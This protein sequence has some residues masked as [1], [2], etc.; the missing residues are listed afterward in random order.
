MTM[1]PKPFSNI[2]LMFGKLLCTLLLVALLTPITYFTWRASQPMDFPEFHGLAYSQLLTERQAAYDQ[3]AYSYQASH[4]NV[5]VKAGICFDSELGIEIV[6]A[7]PY[8]GL[9]T[10]A[11]VFP[12]LKQH[13]NPLD[14]QRGYIPENITPMKFLPAWW[15]TFEKLVWGLVEYIPEGPVVY[16]RIASLETKR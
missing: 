13:M 1:T 3:L 14:V 9:Y 16:C 5:K 7:W 10:L 12:A 6:G 8:A 15:D 11:A 2:I 4:P